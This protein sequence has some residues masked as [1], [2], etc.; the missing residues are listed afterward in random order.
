MAEMGIPTIAAS[1][2]APMYRL[3]R[4]TATGSIG[5]GPLA[6]AAPSCWLALRTAPVVGLFESAIRRC[7]HPRRHQAQSLNRRCTNNEWITHRSIRMIV[8]A[9][10]GANGMKAK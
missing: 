8:I 10:H 7:W 4:I 9:H 6:A 1:R 3:E 2:S 5:G